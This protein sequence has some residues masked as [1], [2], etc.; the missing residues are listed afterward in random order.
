MCLED[1]K[2]AAL[3]SR[4]SEFAICTCIVKIVTFKDIVLCVH[5]HVYTY[6]VCGRFKVE[7]LRL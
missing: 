6:N 5:V 7:S 2:S 4:D 3:Q 1:I